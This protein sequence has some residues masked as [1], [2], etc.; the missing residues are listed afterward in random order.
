MPRRR[1]LA[2]VPLLATFAPGCAAPAAEDAADPSSEA[3]YTA[4]DAKCYTEAPRAGESATDARARCLTAYADQLL[5]AQIASGEDARDKEL[6]R[7]K[8]KLRVPAETGCFTEDVSGSA[9]GAW[10]N[11]IDSERDVGQIAVQIKAAVEFLKYYARDLDG[12]PNHLFDTVE[13]CPNGQVGGDLA[14]TGSRLRVGMRTGWWGRYGLHT[15]TVLR[16]KWTSG[17]HL[18]GDEAMKALKG[19]RWA[20]I[21]PVGTPRTTLRK[22]LRGI[23]TKVRQRLVEA[24]ARP[25]AELRAE[26]ERIVRAETAEGATDTE[27]ASIQERAL[28]KIASMTA[29]ELKTLARD[30][31]LDLG[32]TEVPEGVEEGSVSMRDVLNHRDVKVSVTQRGFVN[33]QNYK[34]I[35]VDLDVFLPRSAD[36]SRYVEATRTETNIEVSQYGFVN[37]Q[38]NDVIT[39]RLQ[40]LYGRSAQTAS[41]D[42]VLRR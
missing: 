1:L 22:A 28:Q 34:Q 26:L 27:G 29:S 20:A 8:G 32:R 16:Q 42:R 9:I 17:E 37:V 6:A 31:A 3:A 4:Q 10:Q 24:Q 30:W 5:A 15:S 38:L 40:V 12:Y 36:F 18:D 7:F 11:D 35:S 14:L 33:V 13:L 19:I 21:D 41:L 39:V 25:D 2:L 23:V